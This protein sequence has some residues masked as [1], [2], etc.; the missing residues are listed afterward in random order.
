MA[1]KF[2]GGDRVKAKG[3]S[4]GPKTEVSKYIAKKEPIFGFTDRDTYVECVWY[5]N[6]E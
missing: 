3:A 1:R 2:K 5:R 4:S 6:G